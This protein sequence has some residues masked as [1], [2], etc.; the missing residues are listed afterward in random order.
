MLLGASR[1]VKCL[2]L[3]IWTKGTLGGLMVLLC[4]LNLA[5]ANGES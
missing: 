1:A 4:D 3:L 5:F 2:H